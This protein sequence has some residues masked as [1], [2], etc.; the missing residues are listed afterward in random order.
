MTL[1][2]RRR[3]EAVEMTEPLDIDALGD[4]LREEEPAAIAT[5][6]EG[7]QDQDVAAL[8]AGLAPEEGARLIRALA[9]ERA[10]DVFSYLPLEQQRGLLGI[11]NDDERARLLA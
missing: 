8:A 2:G 4:R 3:D 9:P 11:L 7:L 10:P 5:L 6:L 1:D